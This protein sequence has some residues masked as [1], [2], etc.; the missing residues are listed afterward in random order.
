MLKYVYCIIFHHKYV[1]TL[2]IV[3]DEHPLHLSSAR[4][5][6]VRKFD[7]N[8]TKYVPKELYFTLS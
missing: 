1:R 2:L 6:N 5:M 7:V 3:I 8:N 4:M